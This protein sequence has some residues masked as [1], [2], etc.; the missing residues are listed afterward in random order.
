MSLDDDY[1]REAVLQHRS[2]IRRVFWVSTADPSPKYESW[3][4][5]AEITLVSAPNSTLAHGCPSTG[6][7]LVAA[8][9]AKELAWH[10]EYQTWIKDRYL[11]DKADEL[12]KSD[13]LHAD[14]KLEQL[15][16]IAGD[17]ESFGLE[18]PTR[19]ASQAKLD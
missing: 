2:S 7:E 3:S 5:Q 19:L 14:D 4:R 11:G 1:L 16:D 9:W 8:K 15:Q 18:V 13:S 10:D 12:L 17:Y 6:N